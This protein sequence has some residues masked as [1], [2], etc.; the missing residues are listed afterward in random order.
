MEGRIMPIPSNQMITIEV[1]VHGNCAA[2]GSNNRLSDFSYFYSRTNPA[3]AL[4]TKTQ[5]DTA[6]QTAIVVPTAAALNAR[7]L[8]TRNSIRYLDDVQD[9]FVD[10]SHAAVGAIAGDSLTTVEAAFLLL[11]TGLRGKSYLGKKHLFPMSESDTTSGTDDLF[12]AGC[13]ARLATI[14]TAML[15]GFTDASGNVW[16]PVVFAR[17]LSQVKVNPTSVIKNLVTSIPVNKRVGRMRHREVKSV[18]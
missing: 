9:A 18:Y 6:F 17:K 7:W 11:R 4:P 15:A 1:H 3:L 13:L 10:F 8:Q 12:N 2:G 5:I 14:A 16:Q